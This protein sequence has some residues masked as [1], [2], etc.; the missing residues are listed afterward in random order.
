MEQQT[1][2][3][4]WAQ[5]PSKWPD[6]PEWMSFYRLRESETCPRRAA[7]KSG[8][9]PD[10]W[11]RLGY[12]PKPRLPALIG[13]VVHSSLRTLGAK[14]AKAGCSSASEPGAA[15]LLK[16]LGGLSQIIRKS[17][18]IV[19]AEQLQNPRGLA[20]RKRLFEV[21]EAHMPQAREQ[22]Q[23]KLSHLQFAKSVVAATGNQDD[24]PS[25]ALHRSH[26]EVELRAPVLRWVGVADYIALFEDYCEI[27][28]FKSGEP[29]EEHKLQILIYAL[30]WARDQKLNPDRRIAN[31][32]TLLYENRT[33]DVPAPSENE[34]HDLEG[35]IQTRTQLARSG[36][37][38]LP[39]EARPSPNNCRFCDVRHL[40]SEYWKPQTQQQLAEHESSPSDYAD[41]EA[42]IISQQGMKCWKA[43]AVSSK[44]LLH[45]TPIL[46]RTS[47]FDNSLD[48]VLLSEAGQHHVRILDG[49]LANR[50][51]DGSPTLVTISEGSEGFLV[52][53][54]PRE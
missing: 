36:F 40:C 18:D 4:V 2:A 23:L 31:R 42:R 17:L 11:N 54:R 35:Q 33:V 45:G 20:S 48:E 44:A 53:S 41:I 13:Q 34:L 25:R 49:R 6:A 39:P 16:T 19:L 7:L 38:A 5:E 30:L 46:L 12:P 24:I 15:A 51:S 37:S 43:I 27:V 10:I 29:D 22:V 1:R 28:D 14:F 52:K 9:Y 3:I 32:L 50:P 26:S 21:L 8:A 47:V